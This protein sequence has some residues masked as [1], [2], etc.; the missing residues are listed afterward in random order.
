MAG[1]VHAQIE[2]A[3]WQDLEDESALIVGESG[4]IATQ[5]LTRQCDLRAPN[6]TPAAEHHDE[7][8]DFSAAD[9]GLRRAVPIRRRAPSARA[10][11]RPGWSWYSGAASRSDTASGA[12]LTA[13]WRRGRGQHEHRRAHDRANGRNVTRD[14]G[15]HGHQDLTGSPSRKLRG[16]MA[17]VYRP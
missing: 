4:S 13:R 3:R 6:G 5:F 10:S 9:G 14:V 1:L 11:T 12:T 15:R 17:N 8:S 16:R 2:S 7:T